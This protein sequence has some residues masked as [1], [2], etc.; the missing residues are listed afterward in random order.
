[1]VGSTWGAREPWSCSPILALLLED[2]GLKMQE[3]TL[4]IPLLGKVHIWRN[5]YRSRT[6]DPPI[7]SSLEIPANSG[8][9]KPNEP[10]STI[11]EYSYIPLDTNNH[12]TSNS[13]TLKELPWDPLSWCIENQ[14]EDF[15]HDALMADE[16]D[17]FAIWQNDSLPSWWK[18][19]WM[20]IFSQ[21]CVSPMGYHG[22]LVYNQ[23]FIRTSSEIG[24]SWIWESGV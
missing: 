14:Y 5:G 20:G 6:Q 1:M 18:L 8:S 24:C 10:L 17:Q 9:W 7:Q 2:E 12:M 11:P 23:R 4:K 13:Q 19:I 16:I 22:H 15:F 21:T 3:L